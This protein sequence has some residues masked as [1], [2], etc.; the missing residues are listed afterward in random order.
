M[1]VKK[2]SVMTEMRLL[3]KLCIAFLEAAIGSNI[4]AKDMLVR[5]NFHVLE[6]AIEQVTRAES[7]VLKHRVK[8]GL[9]P[10]R[11]PDIYAFTRN[12]LKY[13]CFTRNHYPV[14]W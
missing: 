11:C 1:E 7:N 2:K 4:S 6:V 12:K 14:V 8:N 13:E 10:V 5:T 3:S 9:V